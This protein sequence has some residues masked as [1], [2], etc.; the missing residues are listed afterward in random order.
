MPASNRVVKSAKVVAFR[1]KRLVELDEIAAGE[2]DPWKEDSESD[3][4]IREF[5]AHESFQRQGTNFHVALALLY[6]SKPEAIK[7]LGAQ[8]E[9]LACMLEV[10]S[11]SSNFHER[12]QEVID[13]AMERLR[14]IN[15][16]VAIREI[17]T[18]DGPPLR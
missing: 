2:F 11:F 1:C 8:P 18:V 7:R 14:V 5:F 4:R 10:L 12:A 9:V 15:S 6:L 13:E 16:A 3:R 17:A